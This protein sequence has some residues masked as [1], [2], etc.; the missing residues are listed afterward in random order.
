MKKRFDP[1]DLTLGNLADIGRYFGVRFQVGFIPSQ[2]G[3]EYRALLEVA[4]A[5]RIYREDAKLGRNALFKALDTL[6][7]VQTGDE[8]DDVGTEKGGD[9]GA[10]SA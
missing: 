5:A 1:G 10:Q 8:P 2:H 7:A 6:D 4:S 9:D 3:E